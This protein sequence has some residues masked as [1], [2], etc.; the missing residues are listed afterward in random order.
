MRDQWNLMGH[1]FVDG[2]V[3]GASDHYIRGRIQIGSRP[4]LDP[5]FRRTSGRTSGGHAAN[6]DSRIKL[7]QTSNYRAVPMQFVTVA[8]GADHDPGLPRALVILGRISDEP[9]LGHHS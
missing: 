1:A 8:G 5:T 6:L 9:G 3:P 2:V 4:M 7:P